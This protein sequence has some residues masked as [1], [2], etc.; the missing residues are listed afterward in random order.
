MTTDIPER[1]SGRRS[2]PRA[3][4]REAILRAAT[5]LF[6]ERGVGSTSMD[7][8][9][10]RA[11]VAKG[12]IFYNF[13][14]KAR[15]VEV[16]MTEYV[17]EVTRVIAQA[18][19]GT[20]G[21]ARTRAILAALL[22]EVQEHPQPAKVMVAEVFRTDRSWQDSASAWRDAI[23]GPLTDALA[24][25]RGARPG[26]RWRVMAAAQTGAILTAGMEWLVFHP[27][28]AYDEVLEAALDSLGLGT[29]SRHHES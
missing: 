21:V 14:S 12:S 7:D 23:M 19:E 29:G 4:V 11:E 9:A 13:S 16:L 24:A 5:E 8:I 1:T 27:E 25:E 15:L 3:G 2:G 22:R 6:A 17:H 26:E 18:A 10:L 20:T 28:L